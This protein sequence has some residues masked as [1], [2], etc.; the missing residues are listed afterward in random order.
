[1]NIQQIQT[2]T[3]YFRNHSQSIVGTI[4]EGSVSNYTP[5]VSNLMNEYK[6]SIQPLITLLHNS[7]DRLAIIGG[8]IFIAGQAIC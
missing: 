6:N 1:M 3:G 2:K 8:M 4:S 7:T 5:V